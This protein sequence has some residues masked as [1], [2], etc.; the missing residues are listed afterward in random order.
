MRTPNLQRMQD[1][2]KY[3]ADYH[4][5]ND[6]MPSFRTIKDARGYKSMNTLF[7]DIE[8]LK[9]AGSLIVDKENRLRLPSE[10]S[11]RRSATLVGGIRCGMPTDATVE[12]PE[13]VELPTVLFGEDLNRVIMK[14]EGDSMIGLG[15]HDGDWLIVKRQ[16]TANVGDIVAAMLSCGEYTCKIFQRDEEGYYL[17]A[18]NPEYKPIRPSEDWFIYG[19]VQHVIHKV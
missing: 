16:P 1:T 5:T 19:I 9:E 4:E 18:A 7:A 6:R 8:R 11:R 13:T 3:I 10:K 17:E 14:A 2:L 15:I 12:D